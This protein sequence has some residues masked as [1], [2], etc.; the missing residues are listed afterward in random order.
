[1]TAGHAPA[2]RAEEILDELRAQAD[3]KNVEGMERYGISAEGTLG[4]SMP[5]IRTAARDLKREAGRGD[6][7]EAYRHELAGELWG[8]GVHEA[9][10]LAA[11]VDVPSLVTREQMEAWVIEIDSW[12]VCDQV[13]SNLFDKTPW[14][15][16][17][18]SVWTERDEEFVKRAGFVLM[19]ALA[20]HDKT[21]PDESFLEMLPII[22]R[23]ATDERNFVKKA[24][25]WALRQIG[26]RSIELNAAAVDVA[27]RLAESEDRAARWVGKDAYREL[28]SEKTRSR[29]K[30]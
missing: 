16:E 27:A 13:T 20:V 22:E 9:R 26:K 19:A 17:L 2:A 14:A 3:P 24:V 21:G 18:T 4:V 29:I 23:R 12:D 30:R 1:V 15:Y 10:I 25:N 6:A 11:L 28:S 8:S 7:A 5:T